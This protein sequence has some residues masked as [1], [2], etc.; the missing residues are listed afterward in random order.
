MWYLKVS[1]KMVPSA[2]LPNMVVQSLEHLLSESATISSIQINRPL[3]SL[4]QK[5]TQGLRLGHLIWENC[6][7][8]IETED[9][10]YRLFFT[11]NFGFDV[12]AGQKGEDILLDATA[13]QD[14]L[15]FTGQVEKRDPTDTKSIDVKVILPVYT[16]YDFAKEVKS[17]INIY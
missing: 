5:D 17:S 7:C 2:D 1:Q 6:F 13:K 10:L 16:V 9:A 4:E 12:D 8:E 15:Y 14:N 3:F 11:I